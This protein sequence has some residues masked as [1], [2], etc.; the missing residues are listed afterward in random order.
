MESLKIG[1]KGGNAGDIAIDDRVRISSG[2]PN[3]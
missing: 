1:K 3:L 2:L